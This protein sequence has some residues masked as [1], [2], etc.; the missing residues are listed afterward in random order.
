M[1]KIKTRI[2][3]DANYKAIYL[4]GKTMRL[5][6]DPKKPITNLKYP[7]FLDI[8]I[9]NFCEGNCPYC[10][11]DALDTNPHD[12]NIVQ[13]IKDYFGNLTPNQKPFQVALGGGEP[14]SHPHFIEILKTFADL[15]IVPNYTTNGMHITQELLEATKKY[16][17]GVAVSTHPHLESY[18][19]SATQDFS[20]AGIKTM[21]HIIISDKTSIDE[22]FKIFHEWKDRVA[23][24][25][26]LPHMEQGRGKHIDI[27]HKY[28]LDNIDDPTQIAF[29]ANF[30]E[31][32]KPYQDKFNLSLYEPEIM[33]K[34]L[35]LPD[36]KM[37]K[38]SFNINQIEK[39]PYI[40]SN[41]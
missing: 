1:N 40:N 41:I 29:G 12:L 6:L 36:N 35:S 15:D 8:K 13:K 2:D 17:E 9:T 33:S 31:L 30:F 10:Y 19:K 27:P 23:Y 28:L 11:M 25:V 34:F 24:F 4:N 22:F 26:L 5:T 37:Y 39:N 7:E 32:L 18:W 20:D 16:S 14:T 21:L 3:K 38:S